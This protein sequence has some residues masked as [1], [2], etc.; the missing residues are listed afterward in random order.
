MSLSHSTVP[1]VRAS[2]PMDPKLKE[3][4]R[5]RCRPPP[6]PQRMSAYTA[7]PV[8]LLYRID[9]QTENNLSTALLH[10]GLRWTLHETL[11]VPHCSELEECTICSAFIDHLLAAKYGEEDDV[12]SDDEDQTDGGQS[13]GDDNDDDLSPGP[14][15]LLFSLMH[16]RSRM[17]AYDAD[18]TDEKAMARLEGAMI[19][20]F[21]DKVDAQIERD[22]AIDEQTTLRTKFEYLQAAHNE[23]AE[24]SRNQASDCD[25]ERAFVAVLAEKLDAA[26][27]ENCKLRAELD[28]ERHSS[29][30]LLE[31][32]SSTV[33]QLKELLG[34]V[35]AERD[36]L[37]KISQDFDRERLAQLM[38]RLD[39]DSTVGDGGEHPN[40]RKRRRTVESADG[41]TPLPT[42]STRAMLPKKVGVNRP[43]RQGN[44]IAVIPAV[45]KDSASGLVVSSDTL[46]DTFSRMRKPCASDDPTAFAKWL[47]FNS[48][49]DI[50]G[51]P[52]RQGAVDLRDVRGY[53][54]VTA[55]VLPKQRG[56]YSDLYYRS[57]FSLLRI[58]T[59]PGRYAELVRL[60]G[61]RVADTPTLTPCAFADGRLLTDDDTA[62]L[63]AAK[64][65]TV[66]VANDCWQY[67]FKFVEAE[68]M[69][70]DTKLGLRNVIQLLEQARQQEAAHG[71]PPGLY[72]SAADLYRKADVPDKK[73][74]R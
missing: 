42:S 29:R 11:N 64:G 32:H 28:R 69:H 9:V 40:S 33:S 6:P 70:S 45:P 57:L 30:Q 34:G 18:L 35:S 16:L 46:W 48:D 27:T 66:E 23:L 55:R 39:T 52:V 12:D 25:T 2:L 67:C 58:L 61:V 56:R 51:I 5:A 36:L 15:D 62:R 68:S 73:R 14:M 43:N 37:K 50:Q 31:S 8:R 59:I 54:Q 65:M 41:S 13:D 63:L 1:H 72:P 17:K 38:E 53:L 47:Q 44:N 20:L 24:K 19:E 21:G 22:K 3:P 10:S 26:H 71:R 60:A 74:R 4:R 49:V 7:G